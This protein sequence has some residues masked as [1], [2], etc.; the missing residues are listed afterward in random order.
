MVGGEVA[1]YIGC[2]KE[3]DSNNSWLLDYFSVS[4]KFQRIGIGRSL[5]SEIEKYLEEQEFHNLFIETCSC[6]GEEVARKFYESQGYKKVGLLKDYYNK[7][8]SKIIYS[9]NP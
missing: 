8:H 7:S 9:K 3:S 1:G 6:K 2:F 5:L 4:K